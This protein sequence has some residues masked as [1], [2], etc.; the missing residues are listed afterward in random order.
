MHMHNESAKKRDTALGLLRQLSEE[1]QTRQIDIVYGDW[2]QGVFPR[3]HPDSPVEAVFTA[4]QW[5]VT[6]NGRP[7]FGVD[8][9]TMTAPPGVCTCFLIRTVSPARWRVSSHGLYDA[10]SEQ[11]GVA[12]ND[13]TWHRP[14]FVLL[15]LG[16]MPSGMRVR[17]QATRQLRRQRQK[18]NRQQRELEQQYAAA[19]RPDALA[20]D[21]PAE[22]EAADAAP[23]PADGRWLR[24]RW[25]TGQTAAGWQ[26][27]ETWHQRTAEP[28]YT[29]DWWQADVTRERTW[30]DQQWQQPDEGRAWWMQWSGHTYTDEWASSDWGNLAAY[31]RNLTWTMDGGSVSHTRCDLGASTS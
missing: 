17:S 2:N 15:T 28:D 11:L 14:G 25:R 7:F 4:P 21:S 3:N 26:H 9:G 1:L 10:T 18:R 30:H 16:G 29:S 19:W 24:G 12:A 23:E 8:Y 22:E 5:R 6:A 13:G 20:E 31:S 27:D